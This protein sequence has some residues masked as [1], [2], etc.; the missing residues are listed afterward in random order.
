MEG[1]VCLA[2]PDGGSAYDYNTSMKQQDSD[3]DDD[4]L[5]DWA[6]AVEERADEIKEHKAATKAWD[7]DVKEVSALLIRACRSVCAPHEHVPINCH[8]PSTRGL[9]AE[10]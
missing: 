8:N 10:G 2:A 1:G 6:I 9:R 4:M 3:I 7:A 5:A